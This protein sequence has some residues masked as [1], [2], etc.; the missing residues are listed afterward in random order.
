MASFRPRKQS[1]ESLHAAFALLEQ[2][3]EGLG[4]GSLGEKLNIDKSSSAYRLFDSSLRAAGQRRQWLRTERTPTGIVFVR[5]DA[6]A[7]EPPAGRRAGRAGSS[8]ALAVLASAAHLVGEAPDGTESALL[9]H[10]SGAVWL[11]PGPGDTQLNDV[12]SQK[13]H[14]AVDVLSKVLNT[15]ALMKERG[16]DA[17]TSVLAGSRD[18]VDFDSI[19]P[20]LQKMLRNSGPAG[21]LSLELLRRCVNFGEERCRELLR[22]M[23]LDPA[24]GQFYTRAFLLNRKG[25]GKQPWHWD[26]QRVHQFILYLTDCVPTMVAKPREHITFDAALEVMRGLEANWEPGAAWGDLSDST[27]RRQFIL[28]VELIAMNRAQSEA[29]LET[30]APLVPK[31][32]VGCIPGMLGHAGATALPDSDRWVLFLTWK[33]NG[34]AEAYSGSVQWNPWNAALW[35]GATSRYLDL[36]REYRQ[37]EPWRF[38]DVGSKSATAALRESLRAFAEGRHA[39][40]KVEALLRSHF[41]GG[42]LLVVPTSG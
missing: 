3:P 8:G 33:A 35:L 6:G 32:T 18:I 7:P 42:K 27:V 37:Y 34:E 26:T 24:S 39:R 1:H 5:V 41:P 12:T 19:S 29:D 40:N 15:K 17:I 23:R 30:P 16:G 25:T 31:G 20:Q 13:I 9:K 38:I 4:V 22:A 36:L 21:A 10:G 28:A 2:Y 11:K 14:D